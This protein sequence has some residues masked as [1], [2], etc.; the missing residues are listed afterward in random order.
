MKYNLK[1][2]AVM[3]AILLMTGCSADKKDAENPMAES[4]AAV[5][6]YVMQEGDTQITGEVT[7]IIGN[8]VTLALG[9]VTE[10]TSPSKEEQQKGDASEMPEGFGNGEMPEGFG[11]GEMPEGFGNGEMPEGFGKN[12]RNNRGG[13]SN[14]S[15]EKSGETAS[16]IIPAG[17]T[18]TG[19][20]GRN[21]DYSSISA[22]TMLRLTL[23]AD[24]YVVAAE[25]I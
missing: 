19:I 7:E 6:E 4:T 8:E 15:I 5:T 9:E 14:S 13:R 12:G 1:L 2:T 20:N 22:G 10:N 17:M 11:N 23:N 3:T 18:V 24:G 16:Y 21:S 25:I